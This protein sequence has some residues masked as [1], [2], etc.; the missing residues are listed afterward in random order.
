MS[1]VKTSNSQKLSIIQSLHF[2]FNGFVFE[3]NWHFSS[4]QKN[5]DQW[6]SFSQMFPV[7]WTHIREFVRHVIYMK[8]RVGVFRVGCEMACSKKLAPVRVSMIWLRNLKEI[9]FDQCR[10]F[11]SGMIKWSWLNILEQTKCLPFPAFITT[12][13]FF[14]TQFQTFGDFQSR[15]DILIFH[16]PTDGLFIILL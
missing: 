3:L 15:P 2:F 6:C 10:M 4:F 9:Q 12:I 13:P 7:G 1:S 8:K 5:V 16:N 14:W 11:R